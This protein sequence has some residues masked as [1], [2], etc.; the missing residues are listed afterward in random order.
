MEVIL[1]KME[2]KDKGEELW[3]KPVKETSVYLVP[4][5][6]TASYARLCLLQPEVKIR[7]ISHGHTPEGVAELNQPSSKTFQ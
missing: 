6:C 2:I 1:V 4:T 5:V 3:A 7:D